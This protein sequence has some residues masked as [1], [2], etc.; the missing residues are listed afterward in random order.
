MKKF[1]DWS[2]GQLYPSVV[3][4]CVE[5]SFLDGGL[6]SMMIPSPEPSKP[7]E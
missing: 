6:L 1:S 4:I 3:L 2:V 5:K 7:S